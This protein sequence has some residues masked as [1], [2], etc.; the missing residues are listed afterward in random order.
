MAI[1]N[2][3]ENARIDAKVEIDSIYLDG[4]GQTDVKDRAI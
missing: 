2:S 4:Y 3:M 1:V